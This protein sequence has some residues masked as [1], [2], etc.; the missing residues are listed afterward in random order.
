MIELNVYNTFNIEVVLEGVLSDLPITAL[1]AGVFAIVFVPMTVSI[2][3]RKSQ[4]GVMFGDGGDDVLFRRIRA[5]A[6]FLEYVPLTLILMAV[7]E[8]NHA[9]A[10]FL[11]ITGAVFFVA[12]MAHYYV[13]NY[14]DSPSLRK[15]TMLGTMGAILSFAIWLLLY[16]W[17]HVHGV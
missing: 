7:A 3:V 17:R 2:G 12:R 11:Y 10:L 6:N 13:L 1:L 8:M 15:A 16:F 5:H 14:R 9:S 4:V